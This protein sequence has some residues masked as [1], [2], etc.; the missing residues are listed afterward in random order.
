MKNERIEDESSN[1]LL[2]AE[3]WRRN[4]IDL[5]APAERTVHLLGFP[6]VDKIDI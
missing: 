4:R 2:D 1:L 3:I 5:A 6:G